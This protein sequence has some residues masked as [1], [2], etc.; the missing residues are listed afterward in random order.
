MDS[1]KATDT[2][3]IGPRLLKFAAPYIADDITYI[4][5]HS[6]N[7]STFPS[8]WKEAK[9]SPLHKNGPHD[10]VNNYRP[11]SILPVLSK[12][13]EKHVHDC[14]S[15]YLNEHNLLHK[16]QSGFRSQHSCETALVHMID[17]WLNAMDNGKMIVVDLKKAFDLVDHQ[18]LLSKLELYGINNEALMWFNTCLAHRRQQVSINDNKSDFE[19]VTCGVPQG[20]ILGPLLFLLI[21]NDLPLYVYNVSA[22]LYADDTTLYDI[23]TSMELIEQSLQLGLNQLHVWCR[24]NGMVL[25][26]AKTKV[27]LITTSQKRQRLANTSLNLKYMDETLK[28]TSNDKIL[29]VFVDNNLIW[30]DHVKINLHIFGYYQKSNTSYDRNTVYNFINLISN[31]TLTFAILSGPT[32]VNLIKWKFLTLLMR[33]A[34]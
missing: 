4:C 21:I 14:L 34:T 15:A 13:L 16:T 17:S 26:S 1:C 23:Q 27:M 10:D 24:N 6:I 5:N 31:L 32:H 8:K 9:V 29:G 11:I 2:D 3:S 28:M 12:V 19:T 22:D 30:S 7:S 20:S 33:F 25:N 18:I